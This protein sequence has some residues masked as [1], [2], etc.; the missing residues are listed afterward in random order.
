MNPLDAI[1]II[2]HQ[3]G[4]PNFRWIYR[5]A[6]VKSTFIHFRLVSCGRLSKPLP[7]CFSDLVLDLHCPAASQR[8]P[9]NRAK[10]QT[11][12]HHFNCDRTSIRPEAGYGGHSSPIFGLAKLKHE[13]SLL[14]L[15]CF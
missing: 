3:N 5:G 8:S 10:A 6:S 9:R 7:M 11:S 4:S 15:Y 14:T 12:N 13:L 2:I 1:S